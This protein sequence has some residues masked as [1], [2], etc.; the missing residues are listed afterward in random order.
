MHPSEQS[1]PLIGVRGW[2]LF[3]CLVL[4]VFIPTGIM[5][6]LVAIWRRARPVSEGALVDLV[7]A[8]VDVAMLGLAVTAGLLLY[9]V[10]RIGV[11]L[12]ETFF[13]LRLIIAVVA[14]F[15]R[16]TAEASLAII[17]SLAWLIYLIVSER[18]RRTY[19]ARSARISEIFR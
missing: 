5:M 19:P 6:E 1:H 4:M 8:A 14:A 15:E 3:L 13:V 16:Q 9:R 18:V 2:L 12:A 17:V 10:R 11:W 7:I